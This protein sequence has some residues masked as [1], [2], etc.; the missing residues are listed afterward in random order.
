MLRSRFCPIYAVFFFC[1]LLYG[2]DTPNSEQLFSPTVAQKFYETAYELANGPAAGRQ[3]IEQAVIFLTAAQSLDNRAA[4]ILPDMIKAVC[5]YPQKDYSQP[6]SDMLTNYLD[7]SSDL[8]V[9]RTA[10]RYLLD[11]L[12][13]RE[14]REK[15]L[16]ELLKTIVGKNK[17]FASELYTLTGLLM[18]EKADFKTAVNCLIE[19]YNSNKY[20]TLAFEKLLELAPD[21]IGPAMYLEHL[22]LR[23]SINPLDL[24]AAIAF[25][26]YAQ[27]IGLYETAMDAYGYCAELFGYLRPSETVPASIYVPW[28]LSSYN[29]QRNQYK[30][31]QILKSIR[32]KGRFDLVLETIAARAAAKTGDIQQ[33]NQI[34]RSV[35]EK[36]QQLIINGNR[37]GKITPTQLAWFYCFGAPDADKAIEW[38]NKAYSLEPNSPAAALLAYSL[39]M[40]GQ[41]DLAK[42]LVG[43]YEKS[44]VSSL[45]MALIQ[46]A[47]GKKDDAIATLKSLISFDPA[48]LEAER[49]REILAQNGSEY[50]PPANP[51]I[52]L[53]ALQNI[54]G[55]AVV[56]MFIAPEKIVSAQLNFRGS[57]FTYDSELTGFVTVTNNS[58]GPMVIS[59]GGLFAGSIR[60]DVNV[61]G[62]LNKNIPNLVNTKIQPSL[63]IGPGQ[64]FIVPLR[65]FTGELRLLLLAHP[66]ASVNMEFTLYLDPVTAADGRTANRLDSIKPVKVTITRSGLE[67]AAKYLQNRVN[68]F[69]K[70]QQ[71][72]KIQT[73]QLFAGLLMEQNAMA[74]REPLYKFVYAK[75]MPE[76]LKSSLSHG[77]AD[78]DW[79]VRVYTMAAIAP[80]PLEYEFVNAASKNLNDVYWPSRL[81]A[82]SLLAKPAGSGFNRVLNWTAQYDSSSLVRDMAVALG[83]VPPKPT[84]QPVEPNKPPISPV[85]NE[86]AGGKN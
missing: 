80:L 45:A 60:V 38:A 69:S 42:N 66:Q 8:E 50:I 59:D 18:A 6:V 39:A 5:S 9:A 33:E 56:P 57:K 12:N 44:Q 24:D 53:A 28:A 31:L 52:I 36:A 2:A 19:A 49:A 64:S 30:C 21:Q 71:G 82:V 13:S 37:S 4:Y 47:E 72:Q 25:A 23:L 41:S 20:N 85:K 75:W 7:E 14:E 58:S 17:P 77:L 73:A 81:M 83:A 70:G 67:L 40:N 46:L 27:R 15:F 51:D 79:V 62:D 74:N 3:Q 16:Q 61:T 43:N 32:E 76:L 29:T 22:R 48:S 65:I 35:D 63:P 84:Q 34:I 86:P 26:Q 1:S 78:D 10:V 68:L 54:F 55:Q 11:R